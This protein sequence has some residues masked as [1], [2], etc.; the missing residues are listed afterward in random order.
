MRA[1]TITEQ[2]VE[3]IADQEGVKPE[4]LSSPLE[5]HIPTDAIRTLANHHSSSWRLQFE[6]QKHVV[7]VTGN[8]RI[9]ID[10]ER[11]GTSV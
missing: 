9:L 10:G 11:V 1:Q 8:E 6:T 4:N 7:E 2:I 5:D 3:D